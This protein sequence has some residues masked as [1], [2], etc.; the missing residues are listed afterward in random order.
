[1]DSS[2]R[3]ALFASGAQT[4]F[5]K[6]LK[7]FIEEKGDPQLFLAIDNEMGMKGYW[8]MKGAISACQDILKVIESAER[9]AERK[10]KESNPS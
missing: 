5:W 9:S 4:P 7:V 3:K 2:E 1:M 8:Y 6:E 10:N